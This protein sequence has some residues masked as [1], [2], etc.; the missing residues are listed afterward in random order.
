LKKQETEREEQ[1]KSGGI[2]HIWQGP[3]TAEIGNIFL[4]FRETERMKDT[5][6]GPDWLGSRL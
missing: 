1:W 5:R 3:L 4:V 6:I 2:C